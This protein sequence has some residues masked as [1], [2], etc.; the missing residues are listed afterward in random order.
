MFPEPNYTTTFML[1]KLREGPRHILLF[2]E[3]PQSAISPSLRPCF[4]FAPKWKKLNCTWS[5]C[6]YEKEKKFLRPTDLTLEDVLEYPQIKALSVGNFVQIE[7]Q[8]KSSRARLA[9]NIQKLKATKQVC[10][11]RRSRFTDLKVRDIHHI[12]KEL[13]DLEINVLKAD[14]FP[15]VALHEAAEYLMSS[16]M[17][18]CSEEHWCDGSTDALIHILN[19]LD[20]PPLQCITHQSPLARVLYNAIC[21]A[22]EGKDPTRMIMLCA[23]LN[24]LLLTHAIPEPHRRALALCCGIVTTYH[25][26]SVCCPTDG[27]DTMEPS[28]IEPKPQDIDFPKDHKDGFYRFIDLS[29]P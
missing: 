12:A 1:K 27:L 21:C 19:K 4:Q 8:G 22:Q 2:P 10:A 6:D 3:L 5:Y 15:H 26:G 20:T 18:W 17:A 9:T 24:H 13:V 16:F 23:G 14:G 25:G 11:K 29:K 7:R 28:K